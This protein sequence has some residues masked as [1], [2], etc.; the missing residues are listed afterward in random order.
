MKKIFFALILFYSFAFSNEL[1]DLGSSS[2]SIIS[3]FQEKKNSNAA[4][5]SSQSKSNRA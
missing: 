1:P 5:V 2:D 3:A 4:F